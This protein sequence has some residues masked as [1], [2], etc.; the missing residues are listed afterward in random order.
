MAQHMDKGTSSRPKAKTAAETRARGHSTVKK[1]KKRNQRPPRAVRL[2]QAERR[3]RPTAPPRPGVSVTIHIGGFRFPP[4]AAKTLASVTKRLRPLTSPL[5]V[6]ART[7]KI[8]LSRIPEQLQ[9]PLLGIV[10]V[11]VVSGTVFAVHN[12]TKSP[13]PQADNGVVPVRTKPDFKPLVPSAEQASAR[14]FDGKRDMVT[15]SSTFSGARLTV[16]QQPLPKRFGQDPMA[17]KSAADS[18][19]AT[20]RLETSSGPIYIATNKDGGDQL[21]VYADKTVLLFIHSDRKLDDPSWTAFVELL[22]PE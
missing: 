9:R 13:A 19:Q 14:H 22:K 21:A 3:Y 7:A 15:Y 4:R 20:Q 2:S 12:L 11:M 8:Q 16:S 6:V 1:S 18:I 5:R 17:L 10:V